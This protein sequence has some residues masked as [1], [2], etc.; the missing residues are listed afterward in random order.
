MT[1][2][3]TSCSAP[4]KQPDQQPTTLPA[5]YRH[6]LWHSLDLVPSL[7]WPAPQAAALPSIL[8]A[9]SH[10]LSYKPTS[11]PAPNPTHTLLPHPQVYYAPRLA[12]YAQSTFPTI[13][14]SLRLL[15]CILVRERIS[16]VHT[17]QAFSTL[18]A[19]AMLHARTMG[20]KVGGEGHAPA[21]AAR[22]QLCC[23]CWL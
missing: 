7:A 11:P 3:P 19:E 21:P 15:R 12:F 1:Q 2:P 13:F 16:L 4:S 22:Q 8:S 9:L 20:Y 14:G 23:C 5:A 10:C 6:A 18:G 17:H